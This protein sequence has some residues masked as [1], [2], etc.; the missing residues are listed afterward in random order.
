MAEPLLRH[1]I[2][3][4]GGNVQPNRA[5]QRATVAAPSPGQY[6]LLIPKSPNSNISNKEMANSCIFLFLM[7]VNFDSSSLR[8]PYFYCVSDVSFP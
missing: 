5:Q 1:P 4:L 3:L 8:L 2:G 7:E 6:D